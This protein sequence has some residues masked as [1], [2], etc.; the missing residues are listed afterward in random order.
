MSL[1]KFP[2]YGLPSRRNSANAALVSASNTAETTSRGVRGVRDGE[3]E[4]GRAERGGGAASSC[5]ASA[6]RAASEAS[7]SCSGPSCSGA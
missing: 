2:Y 5:A 6:F 1:T 3:A 4:R 7:G